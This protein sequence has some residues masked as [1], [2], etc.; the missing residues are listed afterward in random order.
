M[1]TL[2]I[3]GDKAVTMPGGIIFGFI[4]LLIVVIWFVWSKI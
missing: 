4:I 1:D 3:I 2:L